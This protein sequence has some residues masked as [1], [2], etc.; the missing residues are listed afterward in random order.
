MKKR[1]GPVAE[2]VPAQTG[3]APDSHAS[4]CGDN[5]VINT[6]VLSFSLLDSNL[7]VAGVLFADL[8]YFF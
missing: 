8:F 4:V 7:R 3:Y 5:E 2:S 1:S 6:F